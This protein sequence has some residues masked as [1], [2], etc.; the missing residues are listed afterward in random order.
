MERSEDSV[1]S[2]YCT[3]ENRC[4]LCSS[5]SFFCV[6]VT[7]SFV[8]QQWLPFVKQLSLPFVQWS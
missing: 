6:A 3:W 7:V 5:Y 1:V 4:L 8:Q 2:Y